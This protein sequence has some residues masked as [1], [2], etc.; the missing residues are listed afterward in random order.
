MTSASSCAPSRDWLSVA[1]ARPSAASG[2]F[3][4][5]ASASAYLRAAASNSNLP[6]RPAASFRTAVVA[7]SYATDGADGAGSGVAGL[8]ETMATPQRQA[9][10]TL[11]RFRRN[12][13]AGYADQPS[14]RLAAAM[15]D[16]FDSIVIAPLP[17]RMNCARAAY[18]WTSAR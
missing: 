12:M 1:I 14:A 8:Q 17:A 9:A 13:P 3:D 15:R 11:A 16:S 5:S 2:G 7:S 6:M 18:G 4:G 10:A